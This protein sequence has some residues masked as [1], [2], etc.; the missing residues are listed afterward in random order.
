MSKIRRS[1]SPGVGAGQPP[2]L[3]QVGPWANRFPWRLCH[4]LCHNRAIPTH[5]TLSPAVSLGCT[6][7]A[8]NPL[9]TRM[10]AAVLYRFVTIALYPDSFALRNGM[11]EVIGSIPVR[12]TNKPNNLADSQKN[13]IRFRYVGSHAASSA[14]LC[15]TFLER[16]RRTSTTRLCASR[17]AEVRAFV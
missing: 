15:A 7:K 11:E 14:A 2:K 16:S 12:S 9:K 10:D 1:H 3:R 17:L 6:E 8:A 4:G 13:A 5:A